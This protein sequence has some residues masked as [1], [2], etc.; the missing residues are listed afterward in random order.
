MKYI[1]PAFKP[2][3]KAVEEALKRTVKGRKKQKPAPVEST[4]FLREDLLLK[5][6]MGI[7]L[8]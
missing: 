5:M 6:V 2:K 7:R 8:D 4:G 1:N 3:K